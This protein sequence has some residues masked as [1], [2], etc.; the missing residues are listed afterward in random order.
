[1]PLRRTLWPYSRGTRKCVGHQYHTARDREA[2]S[3]G[4]AQKARKW[5]T[6][7]EAAQHASFSRTGTR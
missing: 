4:E 3:R 5:R 1:M 6:L 2:I 7:Y